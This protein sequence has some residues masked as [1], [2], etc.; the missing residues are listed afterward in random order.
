MQIKDQTIE[1]FLEEVASNAP[2]PGGG[3][4]AAVVGASAAA[5]VE[6]VVNLTKDEELKAN[7]LT[8]IKSLREE[9][10]G[11][12]DEDAAAFDAVMAAYRIPKED[13]SRKDEIQKAFKGAA[14]VPLKT[15][16]LS[17]KVNKLAKEVLKVGN[18]NA[19]SDA[20]SA[21]HLSEASEKSALENVQINL[22]YIKDEDFVKKIKEAVAKLKQG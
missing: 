16:E 11:L 13:A 6:M 9:L 5:L 19:A 4:V 21:L 20:K 8:K 10:L 1:K 18:K 7:T 22:E 15:A 3:A 12:A 2:T 14:E 17:N